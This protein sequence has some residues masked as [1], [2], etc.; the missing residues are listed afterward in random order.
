VE[1]KPEGSSP[2]SQQHATGPYPEPIEFTLHPPT[3]LLEYHYADQFKEDEV[4]GACG[5]HGRG[6]KGI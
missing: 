3:D 5:T 4:S 6:E 2:H 1:P